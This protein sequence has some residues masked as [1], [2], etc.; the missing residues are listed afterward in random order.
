MVGVFGNQKPADE[1]HVKHVGHDA[2]SVK[3]FKII[4]HFISHYFSTW[5]VTFS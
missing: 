3:M 1:V 2:Y 5:F 4:F